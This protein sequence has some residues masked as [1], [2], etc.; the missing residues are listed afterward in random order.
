MPFEDDASVSERLREVFMKD[1]K[2]ADAGGN[3]RRLKNKVDSG[4]FFNVNLILLGM[5]VVCREVCALF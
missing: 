2:Y 1:E 3:K 5:F 4:P